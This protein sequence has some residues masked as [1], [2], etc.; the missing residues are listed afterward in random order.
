MTIEGVGE[1]SSLADA[2][3]FLML[4]LMVVAARARL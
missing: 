3:S 4:T 2:L 1:T